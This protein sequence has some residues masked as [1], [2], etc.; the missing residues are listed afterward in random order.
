MYIEIESF[1]IG[2]WSYA[3]D[4]LRGSFVIKRN[5]A[6]EIRLQFQVVNKNHVYI[7]FLPLFVVTDRA[8][9]KNDPSIKKCFREDTL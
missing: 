4:H 8:T 1:R 6:Y 5:Q 7:S 3:Y 9:P 2:Y